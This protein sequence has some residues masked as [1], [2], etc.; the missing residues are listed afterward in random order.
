MSIRDVSCAGRCRLPGSEEATEVLHLVFPYRGL[1][2][3]HIGRDLA[4]AEANQVLFFNP[5]EGYRVSHP[6]AGG[7]ASLDIVLSPALVDELAPRSL[8]RAGAPVMF[9]EQR[10]RIDARAQRLVA[11]LRHRLQRRAATPLEAESLV[12]ALVHQSLQ[13]GLS[14]RPGGTPG[15]RRLVDRTKV[16]LA[17]DPVRRWR[18][19]ELASAVG[20]SAAYLTQSFQAVEGLPLYRYHLRLRLVRALELLPGSDDLT[21]MALDLGFSSHSHFTTAFRQAYGI[22]PSAFRRESRRSS[23][24]GPARDAR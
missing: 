4:V 8:T 9:R 20:H 13:G 19:G 2:V 24:T 3:R 16:L 5:G 21:T 7:D 14:R 23:R 1:F 15:R 6:V 11:L 12:L 22:T 18:L 10:R 17:S